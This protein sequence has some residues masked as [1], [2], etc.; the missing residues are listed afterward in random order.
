MANKGFGARE[1]TLLSGGTPTI[2]VPAKLDINATEVGI[3]TG[4]TVGAAT[5]LSSTLDV[6]GTATFSGRINASELNA[7]VYF[8][9]SDDSNKTCNIPFMT[10]D[11]SGNTFAWL[12]V[13]DDVLTFNPGT[14]YLRTTNLTVS[15]DIDVSGSYSG[16]GSGL[17]N[18]VTS[19]VAGSG[20]TINNTTG[21]VTITNSSQGVGANDSLNTTGII[22]ASAF[23]SNGTG[24]PV[25]RVGSGTTL[26]LEAPIVAI[27]TNL[28]V[29]GTATLDTLEAT[30]PN[31]PTIYAG[32][33]STITLAANNVAIS[34]DCTVGG[35]LTVSS[36]IGLIGNINGTDGTININSNV[37]NFYNGAGSTKFLEINHTTGIV[38]VSTTLSATKYET[39]SSTYGNG[40]D[41]GYTTIYNIT[42]NGASSYRFAGPGI[43]NTIDNPTIYLHRGFTYHLVNTTGG[44]PFR[45]QYAGTTTGYGSTYLSGSQTGTQVFTVPFDAPGTLEYQCTS[46]PSMVGTIVIPVS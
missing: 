1:L 26:N 10:A 38:A 36:N 31:L 5:T 29:G 3:S 32:A 46:H 45:I 16:D 34:T 30:V 33:G 7:E 41:R 22:T 11:Q 14:N 18:I 35:D 43:V 25:I 12:E 40:T 9:E 42:A 8:Q 20:I 19:L 24:D 21:A 28:T 27:S 2:S 6:S 13:D 37:L 39:S 44:H 23:D 4:L 17:S 15:N